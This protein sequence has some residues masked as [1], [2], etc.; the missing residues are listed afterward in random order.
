MNWPQRDEA[1]RRLSDLSLRQR[2]ELSRDAISSGDVFQ[3][4]PLKRLGRASFGTG[5]PSGT[6]IDAVGAEIA[7]LHL[8]GLIAKLR[9]IIGTRPSAKAGTNALALIDHHDAV[10]SF[11]DGTRGT[12]FSTHR[13]LAVIA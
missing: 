5:W 11:L 13:H 12:G 8:A 4:P 9:G 2:A 1:D 10:W 7:L 6:S 3:L